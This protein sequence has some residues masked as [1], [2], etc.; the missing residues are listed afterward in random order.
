MS[1]PLG[2]RNRTSPNPPTSGLEY[3]APET[4]SPVTPNPE[5]SQSDTPGDDDP[6]PF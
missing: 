4:R 3:D 5:P 6:I 2:S 1:V